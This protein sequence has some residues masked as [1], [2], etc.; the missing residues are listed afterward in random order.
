MKVLGRGEL[1]KALTVRAHAFSTA[2]VRAIEAA[3][4]S[5][6]RLPLPFADGV[7]RPAGTP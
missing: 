5:V 4:G 1:T 6:E 2:A 3:G 7:P